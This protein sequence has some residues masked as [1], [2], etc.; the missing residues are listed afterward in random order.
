LSLSRTSNS[1]SRRAHSS[2]AIRETLRRAGL[3]AD[4]EVR[5]AS[6]TA[7]AGQQVLNE[8]GRVDEVARALGM[9][10]LDGAARLIGWDWA[11]DEGGLEEAF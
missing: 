8:T 9:R 10:S 5:P 2:Q 4:S 1:E 6:L 3:L 11:G 7:W